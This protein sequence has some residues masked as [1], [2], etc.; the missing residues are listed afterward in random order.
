M[1]P[2]KMTCL[3][4]CCLSTGLWGLSVKGLEN[5]IL[6]L[7]QRFETR[8]R[9]RAFVHGKKKGSTFKSRFGRQLCKL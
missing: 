6:T 7:L 9:G 3:E 2:F 4:T 5:E 1:G 8:K